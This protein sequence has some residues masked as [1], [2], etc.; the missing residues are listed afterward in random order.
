M[1]FWFLKCL[2]VLMLLLA[3]QGCVGRMFYYPD[4]KVYGSPADFGLQYETV[5]FASGDGTKLSGWF[6]PAVGSPKGTVIHFHGNA[7]NMT[8]HFGFVAWLPAAGFNVFTFDYRGYGAS[9]GSVS[10]R[11]VVEDGRAAIDYVRSRKDLDRNRLLVLGQ[12]LGG[13]VAIAAIG[14]GD[15]QGIR[16]VVSESAFSSYR[17]IVRDKIGDIPLL[18]LLKTPLSY[19]LIGDAFSPADYVDRIAPIPLLII[20]GTTDPIIPSHHGEW[21]AAKAREPK[22]L[23]LVPNGDHTET[24]VDPASPYRQ[25]LVAFF[26]DALG[27]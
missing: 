25:R 13:A 17:S 14:D 15:R 5:A 27:R 4:H 8:S 19:L 3:C 20:H 16:G 9:G 6:V 11:G 1:T 22:T 2:F 24:F 26:Q 18:S 21:L 23:W 10:R 7:Q 12:S